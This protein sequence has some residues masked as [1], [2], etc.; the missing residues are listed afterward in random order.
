MDA[1]HLAPG[2][3]V[4]RTMRTHWKAMV[5]PVMWFIL[6]LGGVI[7]G[8]IYLP[9][10]WKP[11]GIWVLV[12]LGVVL[13][14]ALFL[15]P[16]LRWLST[17]YTMTTKRLITRTGILNRKG[18]DLPLGSIT[19]VIYDRDL[20]DRILGCGTLVLTSSATNPVE[21]YDIPQVERVQVEMTQL[22]NGGRDY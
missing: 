10:D 17:T 4:V 18:E 16:L 12:A 7:A 3:T 8:L 11:W 14:I 2:E 19:N 6:V 22:L 5:F 13:A 15:L 9:E 21:L 1:K 20:L